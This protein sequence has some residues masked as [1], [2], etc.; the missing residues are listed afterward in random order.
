MTEHT[1]AAERRE[2]IGKKV[3]SIRRDGLVP[4]VLYGSGVE[5]L[6]IQIDAR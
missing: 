6:P 2:A 5:G 3:K 1:L 4:A